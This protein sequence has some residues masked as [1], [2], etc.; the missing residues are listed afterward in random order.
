MTR[1]LIFDACHKVTATDESDGDAEPVPTSAV[2]PLSALLAHVRK[3]LP[4][5]PIQVGQHGFTVSG[6][7]SRGFPVTIEQARSGFIVYIGPGIV[8]IDDSESARQLLALACSGASRLEV[9]RC[10]KAVEAWTL[11][12]AVTNRLLAGGGYPLAFGF[13][14]RRSTTLLQNA[15]D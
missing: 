3:T 5:R 4:Q 6:C 8:E 1:A 12:D 13:W 10:G 2:G 7:G 11:T 9:V 15:A 14:R